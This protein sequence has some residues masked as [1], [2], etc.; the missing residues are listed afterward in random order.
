MADDTPVTLDYEPREPLVWGPRAAWVAYDWAN[1]GFGLI[2]LGPVFAP[3]FIGTLLPELGLADDGAM[4]HGLTPLGVTMRGSAVVGILTSLVALAVAV[5]APVLGALADQRGWTKRLFVATATLGPAVAVLAAL[6]PLF[7]AAGWVWA[8][9]CY[10]ASGACFGLSFPFY[11]AF[12]P[13]LAPP[14]R[15]GTLS[16][17][18]FAAGYVGGAVAL[19]CTLPLPPHLALAAGGVWWLVFSLPAFWLLPVIPAAAVGGGPRMTAFGRVLDT[20]RN[21]RRYRALFLFLLAFLLYSNGIETIINLSPSFGEDV[22]RM[23]ERELIRLFL[24]VQGVAFVGAL[25]NGW[26]ADRIGHK[27]VI[28]GNLAVWLLVTLAVLAVETPGQFLLAGVAIGLVLGGA[29]S[30][31]RALMAELAPAAIRAEAFGFYA[32]SSKAVAIFGPL[33]YAAI[34]TVGGPRYGPAAVLPFLLAGLILLLF[35]RPRPRAGDAP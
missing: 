22:L 1:S 25:A 4:N 20:L 28:V 29:Q 18:G 24:I 15:L 14:E 7:G 5:S 33:L 2:M 11:N 6:T 32:V 17:A 9:G 30:S 19:I 10:V 34:A 3:Y 16:G 23:S 12:L 27:P 21:L 8:A 35:V 26:L 31:S 13:H